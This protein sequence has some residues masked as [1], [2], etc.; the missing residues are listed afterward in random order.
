[1]NAW[2]RLE[3]LDIKIDNIEKGATLAFSDDDEKHLLELCRE[4]SA[5]ED[6]LKVSTMDDLIAEM[7]IIDSKMKKASPAKK[8]VLSIQKKVIEEQIW[9]LENE[10]DDNILC[11]ECMDDSQVFHNMCGEMTPCDCPSDE[12]EFFC[13]RCQEP[14]TTEEGTVTSNNQKYTQLNLPNVHAV[15]TQISISKCNHLHEAI[16]LSGGTTVHATAGYNSKLITHKPDFGLY[17]DRTWID[18]CYWRN[19]FINWP[20]MKIPVDQ[21]LAII[22]ITSALSRAQSGE[23][24]DIGCIGA[25]GRTGTILAIMNMIDSN[26]SVSAE[27]SIGFIRSNYCNKAIE[28][29]SQEWYVHYA[30]H[31]LFDTPLPP[32]PSTTRNKKVCLMTDHIAMSM[33]GHISCQLNDNCDKME[34]DILKW[35]NGE[36]SWADNI[37]K[38]KISQFDLEYGGIQLSSD[39]KHVCSP[40]EHYAMITLGEDKCLWNKE[41]CQY[42]I[43]DITEYSNSKTIATKD[44]SKFDINDLV[45]IY[46]GDTND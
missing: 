39:R 21:D 3:E 32:E 6:M 28:T 1:M 45:K 29:K 15:N 34:E 26:G 46:S 18:S 25:H 4:R 41:E 12:R 5:I 16:I 38:T 37:A 31:K 10:S 36:V 8:K 14:F 33:R 2:T 17:A 44:V 43:D 9:D 42:W 13:M 27:D 7:T 24:I 19:E 11:P 22:Q 30:S 40:A 20:D 23:D 35:K